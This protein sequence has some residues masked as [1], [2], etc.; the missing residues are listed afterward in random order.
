M[1]APEQGVAPLSNGSDFGAI[2]FSRTR[3][4]ALLIYADE[5]G[6]LGFSFDKPYGRG[7]SSRYLTIFAV[8]F[9]E[10][11]DKHP[12]RVVR[13]LYK[14][15]GWHIKKE[16]KWAD[17]PLPARASFAKTAANMLASHPEIKCRAIVCRKELM[18]EAIRR[19]PNKLYNFMIRKLLVEVMAQHDEVT[20]IP[21]HRSIKLESGNSLHDYLET[22]L[23]FD[24]QADTR[25][26]TVKRESKDCLGLQF[27]DMMAGIVQF[28]F[29]FGRQNDM[30]AW[31]TIKDF[32]SLEVF[33]RHL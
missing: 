20:F 12:K 5:S 21:D 26:T 16:K 19:D 32:V 24:L 1:N 7:G 8:L 27:A 10:A 15:S 22:S 28:P 18:R 23:L 29:E 17:M 31:E 33:D 30:T 4:L 9:D 14:S 3:K 6:D 11:Q 2:V 13:Q 25:L